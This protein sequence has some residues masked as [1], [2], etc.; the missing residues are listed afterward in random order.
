LRKSG[1]RE[2]V[3]EFFSREITASLARRPQ[4][5][6]AIG[7]EQ[8]RGEIRPIQKELAS[9]EEEIQKLDLGQKR[10]WAARMIPSEAAGETYGAPPSTI[11]AW[12]AAHGIT[13]SPREAKNWRLAP[14][15]GL[16]LLVA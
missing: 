1:L 3:A 7:A 13:R 5:G 15:F 11:G 14:G 9:I 2:S 10:I 8:R 12:I 6:K 4:Q 16:N